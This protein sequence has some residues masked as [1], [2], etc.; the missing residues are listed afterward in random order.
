MRIVFSIYGQNNIVRGWHCLGPQTDVAVCRKG[1]GKI[2][3]WYVPRHRL[4]DTAT[5]PRS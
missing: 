2:S 4:D 3:A 1:R 5:N